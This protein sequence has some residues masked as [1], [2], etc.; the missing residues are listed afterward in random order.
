MSG[1]EI[2]II[3]LV[4]LLLFGA[5]SIPDFA[6]MIGKGLNEFRKASDEIK[7]EF[8]DNT[9]EISNDVDNVKS[10]LNEGAQ[11]VSSDIKEETA[12]LDPYNLNHDAENDLH[13]KS[14]TEN[15][16]DEILPSK[17]DNGPP[18]NTNK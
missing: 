1:G 17:D 14:D 9:S 11:K 13:D 10:Y 18:D 5:K 4:V 15:L 2:I 12:D 16:S 3:L 7:R 8:R 6:R